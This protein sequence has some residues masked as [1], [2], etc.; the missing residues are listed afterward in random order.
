MHPVLWIPLLFSW[1]FNFPDFF[2]HI[3]KFPHLPIHYEHTSRQT[4]RER[5]G[6]AGGYEDHHH[7]PPNPYIERVSSNNKRR[8]QNRGLTGA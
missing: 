2:P 4:E 6:R 8:K 7:L 5:E 3:I 1:S